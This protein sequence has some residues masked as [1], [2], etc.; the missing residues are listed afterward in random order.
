MCLTFYLGRSKK[1]IFSLILSRTHGPDSA[2]PETRTG[3]T[4]HHSVGAGP[5]GADAMPTLRGNRPGRTSRSPVQTSRCLEQSKRPGSFGPESPFRETLGKHPATHRTR[6]FDGEGPG[7]IPAQ[8]HLG[9][10]RKYFTGD[11]WF[12]GLIF[13]LIYRSIP[14]TRLPGN[15]HPY[16]A[17][18]SG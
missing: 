8:G 14:Y 13:L 4:D 9:G 11:M 3:G 7:Q 10:N 17:T 18:R 2:K 16:K 1:T 15:D 6:G 5:G 12:T